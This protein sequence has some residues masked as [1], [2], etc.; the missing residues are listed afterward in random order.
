MKLEIRR[1]EIFTT[2]LKVKRKGRKEGRKERK[3][4]GRRGGS[5]KRRKGMIE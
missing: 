3:E 5:K 2:S 4:K 1:H